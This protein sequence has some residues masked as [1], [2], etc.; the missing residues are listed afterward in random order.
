MKNNFRPYFLLETSIINNLKTQITNYEV[1]A[2]LDYQRSKVIPNISYIP[3]VELSLSSV[4]QSIENNSSSFSTSFDTL[5]SFSEDADFDKLY[6]LQD[7]VTRLQ[8]EI[9]N[10]NLNES[11]V[12]DRRERI[13]KNK[14]QINELEIKLN[15]T[16]EL[17][18]ISSTPKKKKEKVPDEFY[19]TDE[20]QSLNRLK[21]LSPIAKQKAFSTGAFIKNRSNTLAKLYNEREFIRSG[22]TPYSSSRKKEIWE[23][24]TNKILRLINT[25]AQRSKPANL[26]SKLTEILSKKDSDILGER[27]K[28]REKLIG[29][30]RNTDF[31]QAINSLLGLDSDLKPLPKDTEILNSF[32]ISKLK[33]NYRNQLN[34][35]TSLSKKEK[36]KLSLLITN[37]DE[38]SENITNRINLIRQ[39]RSTAFD[40]ERLIVTEM[41]AAYNI[42]T[43]LDSEA[44]YFKWSID[45][46]H[47]R[48]NVVCLVCYERASGGYFNQGIYPRE[49]IENLLELQI[50]LHP[51]CLCRFIPLDDDH[52]IVQRIKELPRDE[53]LAYEQSMDNWK[54]ISSKWSSLTNIAKNTA[55]AAVS[56]AALWFAAKQFKA[57]NK[58]SS[59]EP[60]APNIPSSV[61]PLTFP[62]LELPAGLGLPE[63]LTLENVDNLQSILELPDNLKELVTV[64]QVANAHKKS[65]L[66]LET[67]LP[68]DLADAQDYPIERLDSTL[69][70]N[71]QERIKSKIDPNDSLISTPYSAL[72]NLVKIA[73]RGLQQIHKKT[74]N[75]LT[76][77]LLIIQSINPDNVSFITDLNVLDKLRNSIVKSL[78]LIK[79]FEAEARS[80]ILKSGNKNTPFDFEGLGFPFGSKNKQENTIAFLQNMVRGTDSD[81]GVD[82]ILARNKQTEISLRK[83]YQDIDTQIEN[84]DR[85]SSLKRALQ[86]T[87]T[88]Q[89]I[90]D[91]INNYFDPIKVSNNLEKSTSITEL[92]KKYAEYQILKKQLDATLLKNKL[93]IDAPKFYYYR[94]LDQIDKSFN[95]QLE[96]LQNISKKPKVTFLSKKDIIDL[97][98]KTDPITEIGT[99]PLKDAQLGLLESNLDNSLKILRLVEKNSNKPFSEIRTTLYDF[100]KDSRS[101]NLFE[102][103]TEIAPQIKSFSKII[104]KELIENE[105]LLLKISA[106]LSDQSLDSNLRK[107]LEVSA[108]KLQYRNSYLQTTQ[109][110]ITLFND[111]Y[112]TLQL[113]GHYL[114]RKSLVENLSPKSSRISK[115][116]NLEDR[117]LK[118]ENQYSGTIPPNVASKIKRLQEEIRI[119]QLAEFRKYDTLHNHNFNILFSKFN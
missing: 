3:F 112:S 95:N 94:S 104:N 107:N 1:E 97:S 46:E 17:P 73:D 99:N 27:L 111:L 69:D 86:N 47:E 25:E 49:K 93:N 40:V 2:I 43:F 62:T 108:K 63:L 59:P 18:S 51:F 77:E 79:V 70:S 35:N 66:S 114:N 7:I 56:I 102:L 20:L 11:E 72:S 85:S 116:R 113:E 96:K 64:E 13:K 103:K 53:K 22:Q 19:T 12:S 65:L 106:N 50:P 26:K 8:Q 83:M 91:L 118:L 6:R 109:K 37:L 76:D 119:S 23:S 30:I 28:L 67:P 33:K 9:R 90:F 60:K 34:N 80:S 10:G 117:I 15:I 55:L 38:S 87:P 71:T 89:K 61:T 54:N 101:I 100:I 115:I 92:Q 82:N 39:N 58:V 88:E 41:T 57:L 16:S 44:Q 84:L 78:N 105:N 81:L 21:N 45:L 36:E 98:F 75:D 74:I 52:P 5:A 32:S 29:G 24:K 68:D 14:K 110:K 31:K 48:R 4:W 42:A